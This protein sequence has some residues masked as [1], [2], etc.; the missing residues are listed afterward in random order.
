[1]KYTFVTDS[2]EVRG[3]KELHG[4]L[5]SME[6]NVFYSHVNESKN[7]FYNWVKDIYQD[8]KLAT[9]LLKS[10]KVVTVLLTREESEREDKIKFISCLFNRIVVVKEKT[11]KEFEKLSKKI[12]SKYGKA[13]FFL[14]ANVMCHI[15]YI[16]SVFSGVRNLLKPKGLLIFEDPYIGD[17]V[18]KTS[19]D[20]IYDEHAFYFSVRSIDNLAK[21]H[22][23]EVVNAEHQDVHGGSMRYTIGHI[24]ENPI[25]PAVSRW[26]KKE[27]ELGLN[28]LKTYD[29]L[30]KNIIEENIRNLFKFNIRA[31][32]I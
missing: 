12:V 4:M 26:L 17:I 28:K 22:G 3:I 13:D 6:E 10:K 5:K 9:K 18:Q 11:Q 20:Q 19:Y 29:N 16:H 27:N 15:P 32:V 24:G 21:M 23:M 14:G 30:R 1:M 25:K 8:Q 31:N 2:I 7:D